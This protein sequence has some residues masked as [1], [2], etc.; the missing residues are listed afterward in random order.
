MFALFLV[1]QRVSTFLTNDLPIHVSAYAVEYV[2]WSFWASI[3]YAIIC[4]ALALVTSIVIGYA[5]LCDW[6]NEPL[7]W[8]LLAIGPFC[9]FGISTTHAF[10]AAKA[11]IAPKVLFAEYVFSHLRTLIHGS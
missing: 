11:V 1:L 2:S 5:I 7:P 9:L 3:A 10:E 6:D 8:F 4:L